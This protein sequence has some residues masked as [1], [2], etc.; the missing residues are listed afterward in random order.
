[1]RRLPL[2]A[3]ALVLVGFNLRIA[4]ASV[5]PLL[6]DL[7]RAL[8]MSPTVAGL[9]TSLPVLCFG[10]LA[11]AAAPLGRRFG[12]ETVLVVALVPLCVGTALRAAGSTGALFAGTIFAGAGIAVA[13]VMVPAVIKAR[14][15]QRVGVLMGLYTA[16]LGVGAAL[17]GGL[18]VPFERAFGWQGSLAIWT[19]PALAAA[20]LV[21]VAVARDH[22]RHAA[23]IRGG[24][25]EARPLL[26]SRLAWQLTVLFGTQ[27]AVFYS[28]LTWLPS[29]LRAHGFSDSAAG[30][31]LSVF[32][33][34]GVPAALV[35]P[36][37]AT[38]V[39]DQRPVVAVF[40]GLEITAIAGLIVAPGAAVLWVTIFAAGQGGAFPLSLTLMVMRSPDARRAAELAGMAQAIGYGMAALGP[41]IAGAL[42]A[43]TGGWTATLLFM[44]L[45]GVPMTVAGLGAG[46]PGGLVSEDAARRA[47]LA[48]TAP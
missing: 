46:R 43:A 21:V 37:L 44:L 6:T 7:E 15:P 10:L 40:C 41:L 31:L 39:R 25:G 24:V 48:A 20:A 16:A 23:A 42:H 4:V 12:G 30:A 36:M 13:N 22:G 35:A 47:D 2:L 27:A 9:L 14:F 11:V 26:R 34:G 33:L 5:P 1:M 19:L 8:G 28:A 17:A 45:L 38:R 32:M 29:I 3:I 18:A